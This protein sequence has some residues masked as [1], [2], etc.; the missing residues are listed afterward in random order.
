MDKKELLLE[1][2]ANLATN[3][4]D[5]RKEGEEDADPTPYYEVSAM[6]EAG[7]FEENALS[8]AQ[9]NAYVIA[10]EDAEANEEWSEGTH[11]KSAMTLDTLQA[12]VTLLRKDEIEATLEY[13]GHIAIETKAGRLTCGAV[14][15]TFGGELWG[16][17]FQDGIVL[18]AFQSEIPR[19]STDAERIAEWIRA[20]VQQEEK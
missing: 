8:D 1:A 6:L 14:N 15:E 5:L 11:G 19:D 9:R 12:V 13:P 20:I 3:Q 2:L 10:C 17:G 4:E 18:E 16:T 7:T